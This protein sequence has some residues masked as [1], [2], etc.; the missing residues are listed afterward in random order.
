MRTPTTRHSLIA[1]ALILSALEARAVDPPARNL[2]GLSKAQLHALGDQEPVTLNG[3]VTTKA[4]IK[5]DLEKGRAQVRADL[6]SQIRSKLS[7]FEQMKARHA[8]TQ[9]EKARSLKASALAEAG[10][11]AGG[12]PAPGGPN[13]TPAPPKDP[14]LTSVGAAYVMPGSSFMVAGQALGSSAG[15]AR[16]EGQFPGGGLN[17]AVEIWKDNLAVLTVPEG[18]SGVIRQS[19]RVALTRKDGHAANT[20]PV[21]F[22]PLTEMKV[23]G[24]HDPI[25]VCS[26]DADINNCDPLPG[27]TFEGTH[28]N[29]FD[30]SDDKGLDKFKVNLKNG[31]VVEGHDFVKGG[32]TL[33][34]FATF[35]NATLHAIPVGASTFDIL[36]NFAVQPATNLEYYGLVYIRGPVGTSHK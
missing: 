28:A 19:A 27:K 8:T 13:P 11:F 7:A 23:L 18:V 16:L 22:E 10:R 6:E 20:L 33:N 4:Q 15:T 29:T 30:F 3:K 26:I 17:L 5:T 36:V 12:A 21:P 9:T 32:F 2:T 31:W 35:Y 1:A 24:S 34:A 14:K 25:I